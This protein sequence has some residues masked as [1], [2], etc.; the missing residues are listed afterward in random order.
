VPLGTLEHFSDVIDEISDDVIVYYY[1]RGDVYDA[2]E[3]RDADIFVLIH[4]TNLFRVK[5]SE[6]TPGCKKEL[7]IAIEMH[8][9]CYLAWRN[10]NLEYKFYTLDISKGS[11]SGMGGTG[12]RFKQA[13]K[14]IISRKENSG[15]QKGVAEHM[16]KA[17]SNPMEEAWGA[18]VKDSGGRP[19]S[20][21]VCPRSLIIY[22]ERVLLLLN[23]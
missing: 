15:D 17:M 21:K 18:P 9:P 19:S 12:G 20:W 8:K 10:A 14:D 2:K 4:E 23:Q 6:M 16:D 5:E 7:A 13:V 22:D 11:V 3:L 1:E